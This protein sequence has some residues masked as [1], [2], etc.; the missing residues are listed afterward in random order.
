LSLNPAP[1]EL[2]I[3]AVHEL[4][5]LQQSPQG[6]QQNQP[7]PQ[8]KKP[9][10]P[11]AKPPDKAEEKK[12]PTP[13]HTGIH[14]LVAGLK[15]DVQHLPSRPNLYLTLLGGGLALAAHP[16]DATFNGRLISHY[17]VVNTAFKPGK[18]VGQTPV[19]M[20]LALATYVY[21]RATDAPKASHFGMDMLRA[22]I[23]AEAITEALKF[24]THRERP[25]HENHQSFPSGHA[26]ITF[27]SATVIERHLGWKYSVVGYTIASYVA[28][29]RLHDNRHY[30]SD[31]IFGSAVGAIAG[32]TVTEHGRDVW[33]FTP[34]AVPGGG[35]AVLATRTAR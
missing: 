21:G 31:V 13:P 5:A 26:S 34:T 16:A 17:D 12:P 19:Q 7:Q 27:A 30:L 32:R 18:I 15:E 11:Q 4:L 29:S 33:T 23:L 8:D 20:G 6:Q 35:I 9:D 2:S 1:A 3:S 14:A 25:N 24:S 22:Q 10:E 28:A